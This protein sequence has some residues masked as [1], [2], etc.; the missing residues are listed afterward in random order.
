MATTPKPLLVKLVISPGGEDTFSIAGSTHK[1]TRS[2]IKVDTGGIGGV[3]AT[4][5]GKQ[6]LDTHVWMTAGKAP[7]FLKSEGTLFDGGPIWRIELA[8]PAWPQSDVDQKR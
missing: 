2:V 6:P 5:I 8:S 4:I 7:S 1:A 3:I